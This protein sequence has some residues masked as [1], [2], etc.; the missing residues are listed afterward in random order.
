MNVPSRC[1]IHCLWLSPE[2]PRR[3]RTAV[4]LHG[5][6]LHSR[7]WLTF[8]PRLA[9]RVP[10]L[11][12]LIQQLEARYEAFHGA[13]LDYRRGWWTPPLGPAQALH[14]ER[15]QIE[16]GLGLRALVSLTDH[17]NLDAPAE[18]AQ[19]AE[20]PYSFEWTVPFGPTF[21][22]LGV[23]NL[24]ARRAQPVFRDL[25]EYTAR[26]DPSRLRDLLAGLHEDPAVLV[27]WN[28]PFWD[29]NEIGNARYRVCVEWFGEQCASFLHA[30]E[31][32]GLRPWRENRM[33]VALASRLSLPVISGGDRHGREPNAA[34]NLTS[35]ATFSEF[36]GEVREGRSEVLLMPQHREPLTL[37]LIQN[38]R[39]VLAEDPAHARGWRKWSDRVFYRLE[40]GAEQPLSAV[41][42]RQPGLIRR[43]VNVVQWTD[44]PG[45][46][47]ALRL[48]MS[49]RG[50]LRP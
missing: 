30:L 6:T 3:F 32:N 48:A 47:V 50:Q 5:H 7:E 25:Q 27:V 33:T 41:W 37:R 20:V 36:V 4:S 17:D 45:V 38:T 49:E 21:F 22:H 10:F 13:R 12:K 26:P 31:W 14:L 28:H 23:H 15:A 35:A 24:P 9:A 8:I 44:H 29:E 34:L 39:D 18:L 43:F 16:G 2:T 19:A 1:P 46:R 11:R 40:N 42:A